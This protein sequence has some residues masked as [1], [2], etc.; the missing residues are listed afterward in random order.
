MVKKLLKPFYIFLFYFELGKNQVARFYQFI[1]DVI[2]ILG[3]LK[4]LFGVEFSNETMAVLIIGGVFGFALT[5]YLLK[6][7]KL[8]DIDQYV[9][10]DKNPVEK[11]LLAAAR[12][13]NG[14]L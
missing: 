2:I 5:G 6:R 13:I 12:K 1:P 9:H 11:E 7:W 4:Y 3:G 8:Y 14:K 10:A